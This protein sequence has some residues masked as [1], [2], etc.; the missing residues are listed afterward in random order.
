MSTISNNHISQLERGEGALPANLDD[1]EQGHPDMY[2]PG[3]VVTLLSCAGYVAPFFVAFPL[4]GAVQIVSLGVLTA[5][6]Y[7]ILNDQIA[8]RQCIEYFTVGHTSFHKRLLATNDPTANGVVWGIYATWIL[9]AVAGVGLAITARATKLVAISALQLTPFCLVLIAGTLLYSDVLAD[10][11]KDQWSQPHRKKHLEHYFNTTIEP[12][13]GYHPVD[14]RKIPVEKR[15]DY[16]A[17]GARNGAGYTIMP[18]GGAILAIGTIAAR[19]FLS[20]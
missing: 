19:I 17:V 8:C 7:G 12:D 13:E 3:V 11:S 20:L 16:M 2:M 18:A 5:V 9:G 1:L 6:T 10:I 15:P 4:A 14:L